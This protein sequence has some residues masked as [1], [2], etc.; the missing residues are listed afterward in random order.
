MT[1]ARGNS[2]EVAA[3]ARKIVMNAIV[4]RGGTVSEVR[5]GRRWELHGHGNQGAF[6]VRVVSRR[7]GDWQS[8]IR[9]A[10]GPG[11]M[12]RHW[13]FV[14]FG[15]AAPRFWIMAETEVVAGIRDRHRDYLARNG[16]HRVQNDASLH[17]KITTGDVASG[18]ARWDLLGLTSSRA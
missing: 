16:G 14:E 7:R 4:H 1:A 12:G 3:D 18:A 15:S 8:S 5:D 9:E 6:R 13:V 10:D 2:A 11:D 17:C